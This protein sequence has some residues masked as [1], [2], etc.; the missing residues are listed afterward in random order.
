MILSSACQNII[1]SIVYLSKKENIVQVKQIS[2]DLNVPFHFLAKNMQIVNKAGLVEAKKGPR[3]GIK[4]AKAPQEIKVMDIIK[5][6]DGDRY[7]DECLLGIG[8][9]DSENPCALHEEW[10]KRKDELIALFEAISL[11]DISRDL[12][13]HKIGRV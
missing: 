12:I 11:E 4:L 9:C 7:F 2:E 6:V 13:S 5:A 3:G 10:A 1:R 8:L